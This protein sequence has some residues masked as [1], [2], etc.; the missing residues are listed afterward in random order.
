MLHSNETLDV[1]VDTIKRLLASYSRLFS[2][3]KRDDP[4]LL[5][6]HDR[7]SALEKD[8]QGIKGRSESLAVRLQNAINLVS[9]N[10][11]I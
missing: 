3:E 5:N 2:P 1:A 7:I 4:A 11:L 10:L 6:L 9:T 8:I